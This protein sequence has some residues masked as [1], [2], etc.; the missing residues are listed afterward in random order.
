[1]FNVSDL[2]L[3]VASMRANRCIGEQFDIYK[4]LFCSFAKKWLL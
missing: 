1:M 3:D 2:D 4:F